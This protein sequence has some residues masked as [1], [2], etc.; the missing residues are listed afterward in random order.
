MVITHAHLILKVPDSLFLDKYFRSKYW[1]YEA[2]IFN[3]ITTTL[4]HYETHHHTTVYIA[5]HLIFL[6]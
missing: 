5:N 3:Q 4:A 2:G 1:R 6:L